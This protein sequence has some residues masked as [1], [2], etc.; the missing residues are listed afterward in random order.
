MI[1]Q[2]EISLDTSLNEHRRDLSDY[3]TRKLGATGCFSGEI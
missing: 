2:V 1:M 3:K